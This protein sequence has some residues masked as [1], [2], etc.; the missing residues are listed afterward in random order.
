MVTAFS[1]NDRL[2]LIDFFGDLGSAAKQCDRLLWYFHS[3]GHDLEKQ[4]LD[5]HAMKK[6]ETLTLSSKVNVSR[7]FMNGIRQ[8]DPLTDNARRWME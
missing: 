5:K 7:F 8:R 1:V 6:R 3:K 2:N 4:K